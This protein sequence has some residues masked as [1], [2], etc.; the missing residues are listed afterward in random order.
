MY[1][2][3]LNKW[4]SFILNILNIIVSLVLQ[5]IKQEGTPMKLSEISVRKG[6]TIKNILD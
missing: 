6:N 2:W 5:D 1:K 4:I 3:I